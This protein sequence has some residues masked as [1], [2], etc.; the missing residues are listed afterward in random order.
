MNIKTLLMQN[1]RF[2]DIV[3]VELKRASSN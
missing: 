2:A 1:L 3:R